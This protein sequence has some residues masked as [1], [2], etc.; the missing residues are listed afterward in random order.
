MSTA[1]Q[2]PATASSTSSE[3][4][5]LVTAVA[6]VA[7][8][9]PPAEKPRTPTRV[10]STARGRPVLHTRHPEGPE[11]LDADLHCRGQARQSLRPGASSGH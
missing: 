4:F 2:G 8:R 1:P 7:A 6:S 10:L 5:R 11:P 3:A 9:W